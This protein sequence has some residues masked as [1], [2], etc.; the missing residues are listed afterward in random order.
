M[1]INFS[2]EQNQV[3]HALS[4]DARDRVLPALKLVELSYGQV[5]CESGSPQTYA[6]FPV[7]AIISVLFGISSGATTEGGL[8]G[9]DGMLGVRREGVTE[10]AGRLQAHGIISYKRG[11]I[12]VRDRA[13]LEQDCCECCHV[14]KLES[15]RLMALPLTKR[16]FLNPIG[17]I[18]H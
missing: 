8:V 11:H 9:F 4:P 13:R 1:Q 3:L 6:Y 5:L 2:P 16:P 15:E 12:T 17:R 10:A 7:D 18:L 14:V